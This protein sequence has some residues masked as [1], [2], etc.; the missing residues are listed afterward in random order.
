M[1]DDPAP[2]ADRA[3][4][5]LDRALPF[6]WW[7]QPHVAAAGG[8]HRL[9]PCGGEAF[10]AFPVAERIGGLA[11]HADQPGS[12]PG[13]ETLH[14]EGDKAA[15]PLGAL[16]VAAAAQRDGGEGKRFWRLHPQLVTD[17]RACRKMVS[18]VPEEPA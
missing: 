5:P 17:P 8:S 2:I 7:A 6:G 11:A 16:A 10:R 14:Q 12:A 15:L 13:P 3:E 9:V 18:G 4:H 1:T